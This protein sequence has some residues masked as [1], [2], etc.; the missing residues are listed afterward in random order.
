MIVYEG[1]K[2]YIGYKHLAVRDICN[3]S[4]D[5]VVPDYSQ[6]SL[7][8]DGDILITC[9]LTTIVNG[10]Q[11]YCDV[12]IGRNKTTLTVRHMEFQL[13]ITFECSQQTV[14]G[15]MLLMQKIKICEGIEATTI[16]SKAFIEERISLIHDENSGKTMI[17]SKSCKILLSL[18]SKHSYCCCCINSHQTFMKRSN[19]KRPNIDMTSPETVP[20][21]PKHDNN[22]PNDEPKDGDDED[23]ITLCEEDHKDMMSILDSLTSNGISENFP[24]LLKSQLQNSKKGM[25]TRRRRWDP[26][27]ISLCLGIYVR[28]P[29]AYTDLKTSGFFVLPSQRLLR[30]HKNSIRQRPG[31]V[32]ENLSWMSNEAEKQNI[33]DFGKHGGLIIDEMSLQDDLIIERNGDMWH[34]VGVVDMGETNNNIDIICQGRKTVRLASHALQFVFHGLS[35]FRWPVVYFGSYTATAHQLYTSFWDCVDQLDNHGFTVDYI[36]ADGASTNRSFTSML[37]PGKP[38]DM[39]YEFSDVF[40]EHRISAIQDIMHVLKK[41]R[42]NIEASKA[43]NK[44]KN[45][46]YLVLNDKSIIWEHWEECFRYNI[47]N[48]FAIHSKLTDEH[49]VLTPA[50]KMRNQLAIQVLNKDML[51]LM[52]AYQATLCEPERLASSVLLLEQTSKMVEIFSDRNRPLSSMD[53]TRFLTLADILHFFNSWETEIEK[54]VM[55]ISKKNLI[56]WETRDDINSS[57]K[58]FVTLC[59]RM[60][61]KGNSINPGF[62]NSDLVENL[63]GQQRGIRNGLNTN[64]T[65]SQYGPAN[66]AIILGQCSVSNKSNSGTTTSYYSASTPCALNPGRNKIAKSKRRSIRL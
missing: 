24:L 22:E 54:S 8:S 19:R 28:S 17:R 36:M 66:T 60:I 65:L 29:Q 1:G 23:E 40:R 52:K 30:Y 21:S 2:R 37:F 11:Q 26:K 38:R 18:C 47:Q 32:E 55:Y 3:K 13:A 64:P 44:T 5:I 25:D 16:H 42:N 57:L 46:R 43:D 33:S 51:Y 7:L 34:L 39:D 41:T 48:G 14:D 50:S 63:F 4:T 27:I 35:G 9:P 58:G 56:T 61:G 45:G 49:I 31:F 15:I 53:D 62:M 59:Q 6:L 12:R 10:E 20:K